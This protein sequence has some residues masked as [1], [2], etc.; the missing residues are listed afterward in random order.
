MGRGLARPSKTVTRGDPPRPLFF[1]KRIVFPRLLIS[2]QDLAAA[3]WAHSRN[4][5]TRKRGN[6]SGVS[7]PL[8]DGDS[9]GPTPAPILWQKDC[10]SPAPHKLTGPRS[11]GLGALTKLLDAKEGKW[12]GG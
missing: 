12:V 7:P 2:S 10:F 1:G 4:F 5:W 8:Q 3:V 11:S 6:G 9:G